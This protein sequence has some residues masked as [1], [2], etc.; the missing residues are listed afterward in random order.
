MEKDKTNATAIHKLHNNSTGIIKRKV[1]RPSKMDLSDKNAELK[2]QGAI[3]TLLVSENKIM[4]KR[5]RLSKGVNVEMNKTMQLDT[6]EKTKEKVNECQTIT[7]NK[8]NNQNLQ[9]ICNNLVMQNN[10]EKCI[11]KRGRPSRASICSDKNVNNERIVGSA[12]RNSDCQFRINQQEDEKSAKTEL[13]EQVTHL[14]KI[15]DKENSLC[16]KSVIF[17]DGGIMCQRKLERPSKTFAM[18]KIN[19]RRNTVHGL[20]L[21]GSEKNNYNGNKTYNGNEL[22]LPNNETPLVK[23]RGRPS[24]S[25]LLSDSFCKNADKNDPST[26]EQGNNTNKIQTDTQ[27]DSQADGVQLLNKSVNVQKK[28]GR[29]ARNSMSFDLHQSDNKELTVLKTDLNL[30]NQIEDEKVYENNKTL[31]LK[32]RGRPRNLLKTTFNITISKARKNGLLKNHVLLAKKRGRPPK[33]SKFIL[34]YTFSFYLFLITTC[35][36]CSLFIQCNLLERQY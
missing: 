14:D 30:T 31:H 13:N 24:K 28:R 25:L 34:K 12:S 8:Q 26:D 18:Q 3:K 21:V 22:L 35:R 5:P 15:G 1:G 11:R 36:I 6:E 17:E 20:T 16:N 4:Q 23:K 2:E 9:G 29:P 7:P 19:K 27:M 10:K 32:K 33:T